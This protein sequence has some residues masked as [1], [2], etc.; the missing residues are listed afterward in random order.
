MVISISNLVTK[1]IL[2]NPI[3]LDNEKA[4]RDYVN[5]GALMRV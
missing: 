5:A 2:K 1:K 4:G 3:M